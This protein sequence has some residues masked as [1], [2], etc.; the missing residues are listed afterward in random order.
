MGKLTYI[1]QLRHPNWQ[2]KRLEVMQAAGF[3][4]QEC[5]AKDVPLNIHHRRY[6]KGR[7]AWEYDPPDLACLCEQCHLEEHEHRALLDML[8]VAGG[9]NAARDAVGLLGGWLEG[10][11]LIDDPELAEAARSTG[12]PLFDFGLFATILMLVPNTL[13]KDFQRLPLAVR[14]NPAQEA[15]VARW[16]AVAA[17]VER[18]GP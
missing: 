8:L 7:M 17:D 9:K 5:G 14:L 13:A 15:A 1:E 16:K 18:S 11:L 3:E 4:C 10:S 2:R 6:V 12:G